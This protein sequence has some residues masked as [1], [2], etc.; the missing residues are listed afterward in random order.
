[1]RDKSGDKTLAQISNS[2]DSFCVKQF[3][4]GCGGQ[5][6]STMSFT[7]KE[8]APRY[9]EFVDAFNEYPTRCNSCGSEASEIVIVPVA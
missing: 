6:N 5:V 1:M 9:Q 2:D 8:L 4:T 7:G 3:C